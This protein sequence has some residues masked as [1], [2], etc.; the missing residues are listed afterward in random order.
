MRAARRYWSV[1]ILVGTLLFPAHN[2]PLQQVEPPE[3]FSPVPFLATIQAQLRAAEAIEDAFTPALD[4]PEGLAE[5]GPAIPLTIPPA[6]EPVSRIAV[7]PPPIQGR[8]GAPA[9]VVVR[10]GQTLRAIAELYGVTVEAMVAAN[11]L[12]N[13]DLIQ[14]GQRLTIPG[15]STAMKAARPANQPQPSPTVAQSKPKPTASASPVTVVVRDG[16]TLWDI[17][18]ANGTS[19][20][21]IA[22]ANGLR[23]A[24]LIYVGQRLI[25]PGPSAAQSQ[26]SVA[27]GQKA[28]V[29]RAVTVVVREGQTLWEI[30]RTYGVSVDGIV[31]ANGLQSA[32]VIRAGQQLKI[33]GASASA[34]VGRPVVLPRA[35]TEPSVP[36]AAAASI[37]RGFLWP[38]RGMVTSRFGWRR[39]EH[40]DGIDIA[41]QYGSP[42]YAAKPGRVIFVGWYYGYGR[43]VIIDH[44]GGL[45]T[46]YGHA[47][48]FIVRN[49]QVVSAGQLIARVGCTGRCWGTHVH[50]E[51]R[52]DGRPV[53]PLKYL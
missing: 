39:W 47:S 12:S 15:S 26:T 30:A 23:S 28:S 45:T 25:I 21:A 18:Q 20:E 4:A 16:Q 35:S 7:T 14:V 10:D 38:S 3:A 5:G 40:H 22:A 36:P 9:T 2:P 33:P 53:D 24:E 51:I 6:S 29:A 50:F 49:G 34:G 48:A 32:E 46:L 37:A 27:N 13:A 1:L 11:N 31:Q 17:A 19:V 52:L 43:T 42:I 8:A 41:A 44:G